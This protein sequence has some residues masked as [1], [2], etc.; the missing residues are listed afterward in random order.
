M[1]NVSLYILNKLMYSGDV[2]TT[3]KVDLNAYLPPGSTHRA[4][5]I[6]ALKRGILRASKGYRYRL[7]SAISEAYSLPMTYIGRDWR[8]ILPYRWSAGVFNDPLA[9]EMYKTARQ[10]LRDDH[11][12]STLEGRELNPYW[13]ETVQEL[14]CDE[15]FV[16]GRTPARCNGLLI[17]VGIRSVEARRRIDELPR[18][19]IGT[20]HYRNTSAALIDLINRGALIELKSR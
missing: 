3:L 19:Y 16:D 12:F 7:L 14:D 11:V 13:R 17:N 1:A 9:L 4:A 2:E 18:A 20:D 10:L 15:D 5:V 8:V 6:N